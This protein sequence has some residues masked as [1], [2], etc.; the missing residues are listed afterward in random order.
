[1]N[2]TVYVLYLGVLPRLFDDAGET[3]VDDGG[4]AARLPYDG[5]SIECHRE[6]I[7]LGNAS[8]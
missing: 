3:G 8:E 4:R 2:G 5:V 7:L 6:P 1:M